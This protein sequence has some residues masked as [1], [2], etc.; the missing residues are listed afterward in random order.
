MRKREEKP[1]RKQLDDKMFAI[2]VCNCYLGIPETIKD[3][4]EESG[5]SERNDYSRIT[6]NR[7]AKMQGISEEDVRTCIYN[8]STKNWITYQMVWRIMRKEHAMQSQ[9]NAETS[10]DRYFKLKVLPERRNNIR[11]SLTK[12]FCKSVIT[13]CKKKY[14]EK[15]DCPNINVFCGLSL[16]ELK[17]T[18]IKGYIY[19]YISEEDFDIIKDRL[20]WEEDYLIKDIEEYRE[21]YKK[22]SGIIEEKNRI[23]ESFDDVFSDSDDAPS[24]QEFLEK[25]KDA[26]DN[27]KTIHGFIEA[28][29][30]WYN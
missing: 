26:Q 10:S 13:T 2:K 16:L 27:L 22:C 25:L 17:D 12:E 6:M 14:E 28:W 3:C 1:N 8:A 20:F 19:G 9:A 24:K 21:K 18:I 11:D 7:V 4:A 5:I 30:N 23:L 29:E 15:P